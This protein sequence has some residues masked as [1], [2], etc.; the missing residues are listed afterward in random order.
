MCVDYVCQWGRLKVIICG[1][2]LNK[3]AFHLL[4]YST[5]TDAMLKCM[6]AIVVV[7]A[8]FLVSVSAFSALPLSPLVLFLFRFRVKQL[9]TL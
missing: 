8:L 1:L 4:F 5:H 2:R 7:V 3:C 9:Y 6:Q